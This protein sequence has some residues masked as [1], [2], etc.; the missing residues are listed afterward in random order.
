MAVALDFVRQKVSSLK[1]ENTS[2]RERVEDLELTLG[3]IQTT[4]ALSP[5]GEK[6]SPK[7]DPAQAQSLANLLMQA[8]QARTEALTF[9]KVDGKLGL[10]ESLRASKQQLKRERA[11]KQQLRARLQAAQ[12]ENERLRED[13]QRIRTKIFHERKSFADVVNR[14]KSDHDKEMLMSRRLEEDKTSRAEQMSLLGTR[15]VEELI[16]LKRHLDEAQQQDDELVD[17][18]QEEDEEEEAKEGEQS[19][20]T[21]AEPR[22]PSTTFITQV[23]LSA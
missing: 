9:L 16:S 8:Q 19:Y 11:E 3:I 2:L 17:E 21:S 14:M 15:I 20:P 10:A 1:S 18:D 6:G 23:G 7:V 5:D 12:K 4:D 22:K 13:N